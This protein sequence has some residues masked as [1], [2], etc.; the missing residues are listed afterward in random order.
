[1]KTSLCILAL[2]TVIA[3][4]GSVVVGSA[5]LPSADPFCH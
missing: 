5:D 4:A 1:M 2:L 3:S